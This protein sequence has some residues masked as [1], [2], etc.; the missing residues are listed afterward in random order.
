MRLS[1]VAILVLTTMLG[2]ARAFE[3]HGLPSYLLPAER[4]FIDI[5]QRVSPNVVHISSI[6]LRGNM[7]S[8]GVVEV[9]AGSGTGFIW[10]N[11]GHIVTNFHVVQRSNKLFVSFKDGSEA[12]AKVI[13]VEPRKD[14]A[15]LKVNLPKNSPRESLQ[16]ADSAKIFVGQ[17]A[18]AIG[19]PF[20]LDQTMTTG[21]VSALGRSIPGAGSVTIRDM[22]QTDASIN[23][24]NS[25]GP[26]LDSRGHLIGMNTAIYSG[27][28]SSAGIGFAVPSNTI[29]RM[30]SQIIKF[31]RVVQPGIGISVIPDHIAQ[32][33]GLPA[34]VALMEVLPG[35]PADQAGLRGTT[36]NR[37]GDIVWGDRIVSIE[38]E[39]IGSYDDLYNVLS[40]YEVGRFVTIAFVRDGKQ[41]ETKVKLVD[42]NE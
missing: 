21:I 39:K 32:R 17:Q 19:S 2:Q 6:Q 14:V 41:S 30:V 4:N 35:G 1:F 28:G 15:V 27:S 37:R 8:M 33:A 25:G 34:G 11:Q 24:G 7:F 18:V 13:G 22:I 12:E 10:D 3:D 23:P 20:G 42:I 16:I 29:Q 36:R 38:K 31:G 5:F 9:P 40:E 26:L